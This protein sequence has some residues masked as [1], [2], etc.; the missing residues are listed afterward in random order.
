M[1]F[2]LFVLLEFCSLFTTAIIIICIKFI[3]Y[4]RLRAVLSKYYVLSVEAD[5]DSKL[6]WRRYLH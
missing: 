1:S 5:T 3:I 4:E 2:P 6:S